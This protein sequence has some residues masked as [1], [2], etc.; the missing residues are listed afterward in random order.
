MA[1]AGSG[2]AA[3]RGRMGV[4][5]K[6]SLAVGVLSPQARARKRREE[7]KGR[8]TARVGKYLP[9]KIEEEPSDSEDEDEA[10]LATG[11]SNISLFTD[12]RPSLDAEFEWSD[13]END[14]EEF[15]CAAARR[16]LRSGSA[17]PA[18]PPYLLHP[19]T[20]PTHP[21]APPPKHGQPARR[22]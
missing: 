5:R 15:R 11:M 12:T 4:I 19:L 9:D 7:L 21:L 6:K 13:E 3:V 18:C 22:A 10:T 17:W 1:A 8:W 14:G 2:A 20:V 16:I